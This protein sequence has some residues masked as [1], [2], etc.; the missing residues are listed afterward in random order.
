MKY[1]RLWT[2]VVLAILLG[3]ADVRAGTFDFNG[4]SVTVSGASVTTVNGEKVLTFTTSGTLSLAEDVSAD[5]L[6]VGGG[7][8]GAAGRKGS[9]NWYGGAGG[10]GGN[11]S[12][13]TYEMPQGTYS[14]TVGAGGTSVVNSSKNTNV[15]AGNAGG[16]SSIKLTSGSGT[17]AALSGTGGSGGVSTEYKNKTSPSGS[18][19]NC[20]ATDI[21]GGSQKKYGN[22]GAGCTYNRN[23]KTGVAGTAGGANTGDGGGG[24]SN[25]ESSGAGGSGVVIVRLKEVLTSRTPTEK[26]TVVTGLV[27]DGSVQ[28]GVLDGSN[29]TRSGTY[30]AKNVGSYTAK[31]T[32]KDG[33]CWTDGTSGELSLTWSITRR[34]VTVSVVAT[35]KVSGAEEPIYPT[36]AEGFVTGDDADVSWKVWRTNLVAQADGTLGPDETV[37]TY[38]LIVSGDAQTA[39]YAITYVNGVGAFEVRAVVIKIAVPTAVTGFVY[40]GKAKTGVVGGEGYALSG[41]VTAIDA[42]AYSA[43]ATLFEGYCWAD[44]ST[45]AKTISWSIAK[46]NYDMSYVVFQHKAS[47]YNGQVQPMSVAGPLPTGVTVSYENNVNRNVGLYTVTAKFAGDTKN[48]NPIG[49]LTAELAIEPLTITVTPVAGQEKT[50]GTDYTISFA[51]SVALVGTDIFTGAL[52]PEA[53]SVGTQ[54]IALGTLAIDDGNG[55]ENYTLMFDATVTISVKSPPPSI[56]DEEGQIEYNPTTKEVV[57]T[58]DD[59][60]RDVEII[61]MPEDAMAQVPTSIDTIKGVT[62]EQVVVVAEA[63]NETGTVKVDITDAFKIAETSAGVTLELNDDP[64]AKVEIEIGGEKE[65]IKVKPQLTDS[66][67]AVVEPLEVATENVELGVKTIPGLTYHLKRSTT[68]GGSF[69]TV[70]S[71]TARGTR[72]KLTDPMVGEKPSQAFYVIEVTK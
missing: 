15:K 47:V 21:A 25:G 60:V 68:L 52:A 30:Q 61:N 46:A 64:S 62:S 24:G 43:T 65:T 44:G 37:G 28:V 45:D 13:G 18:V 36:C 40:D 34:P 35:N 49:D 53:E 1:G 3:R 39:N 20:S 38:D 6:V 54:R 71:E 33:Y 4:C 11:G 16:A 72:T 32:P 8:S 56:S 12:V 9:Q 22:A 10:S 70:A 51:T 31:V 66:G 26:P 69:E 29:Y 14:I 7:G 2:L 67:D 17:F 23:N 19:G 58:P 57:V 63:T 5:I 55:G 27:Y 41:T 42:G 59:G 48:H 50:V